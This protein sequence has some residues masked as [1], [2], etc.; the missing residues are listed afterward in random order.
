[1]GQ[2][3]RGPFACEGA[4]RLHAR[5]SLVAGRKI[6]TGEVISKDDIE[7]KRPGG[8]I[9]PRFLSLIAGTRVI[10][11]IGRD[12]VLQWGMFLSKQ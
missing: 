4:A 7:I 2:S 8:G 11:A 5:R 10:R 9:E 6:N 1:M 3:R 12:E